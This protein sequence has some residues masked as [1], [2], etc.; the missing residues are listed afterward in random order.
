VLACFVAQAVLV[1]GATQARAAGT[2]WLSEANYLR[3]FWNVGVPT[4]TEDSSL[5]ANDQAHDH[6]LDENQTCGHTEDTSN[7]YYTA[8]GAYGGSHSVVYCAALGPVNDV[9]GWVGT[10]L[11]GEQV[12]N[13]QLTVTGFAETSLNGGHAAMDTLTHYADG[14]APTVPATWPNGNDFPFTRFSG[15]EI[16]YT[17][18]DAVADNCSSAYS[19]DESNLGQPLFVDLPGAAHSATPSSSSDVFLK[20]GSGNSLPF[21]LYD[22]ATPVAPFMSTAVL[23]PLHAL[24]PGTHYT[25]SYTADGQTGTWSFTVA[26]QAPGAP[27]NVSITSS[28]NHSATIGWTAPS[29]DGASPIT[30]YGVQYSTDYSTWPSASSTF[31]TSTATT[32]TVTGLTNGTYYYFRVAAINAKGTGDYGYSSSPAY[33]QPSAPGPPTGVGATAGNGQALV[34]WTAPTDNGGAAVSGYDVEYSSNAG[35]TWASASSTFHANTSTTQ[36]VSGLTNG[37]SYQF[38]VAAINTHGTG[39]YSTPS[40]A[41]TPV[42]GL[43]GAP[44][45]V[46]A[47]AGDAQASVH[48]TAPSNNGGATITGYDLESSSDGGS[49]WSP[50][51]NDFH[52]NPATTQVI[53]GLENGTTYE[54]RVAAINTQGSGAY[55]APSN[56]VTPSDVAPVDASRLT[57]APGSTITDGES[58]TLAATLTDSESGEA[59]SDVTLDLL[60]RAGSTAHWTIA[61]SSL[62]DDTGTARLL[63]RPAHNTEYEWWYSG[64]PA[65]AATVS[66]VRTVKVGQAVT[67][68]LLHGSVTANHRV[69]MSG[70]V[71]PNER[72]KTVEL[73]VRSGG[74]WQS[75]DVSATLTRHVTHT[76]AVTS[77]YRLIFYVRHRG[78]YILRAWR[79]ATSSNA[80]G[81]SPRVRLTVT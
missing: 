60:Q 53:T 39:A 1:V 47:A 29:S 67:S 27:S 36:T 24:A 20:D 32:G 43:P 35:S 75:S 8:A 77:V 48:W 49:A 9:E 19:A 26:A 15:G 59:V 5:S 78:H 10:P 62:S 54:F 42:A 72:G 6:Y 18:G 7:A 16:D 44:T 21:C 34:S 40:T 14:P 33:P 70:K 28:G 11:H 25:A 45:G 65:H 31:H 71:S 52:T 80:A 3:S 46:M 55:S 38:R 37:T 22:S 74:S 41:I 79:S 2:D 30:G 4:L 12:L 81:T 51:S 76:G 69:V 68:S 61:G 73:Q 66:G 64:D 58:V 57:T 63:V 50:T 56:A 23:L 13:P 17:G